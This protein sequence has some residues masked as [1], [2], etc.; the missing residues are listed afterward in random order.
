MP[1]ALNLDDVPGVD[2]FAIQIYAVD[3][4]QPKTQPIQNGTIDILMYD[5]LLKQVMA[6]ESQ[7]RHVWS[8]SAA[9]L[10]SYANKAAIGTGY[11]FTLNWGKDAPSHDKIT[12]VVRYR[13][14]Q[15]PAIYSSPSFIT[16]SA[17]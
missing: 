6:D 13:I 17:K 16:V 5:G 2:G 4:S 12:V 8:Y 1:V 3:S 11:R 7:Y 14:A 9:E 10:K 15:G